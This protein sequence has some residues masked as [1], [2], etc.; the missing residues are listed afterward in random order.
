MKRVSESLRALSLLSVIVT[1]GLTL[2]CSSASPTGA[3]NNRPTDKLTIERI[4]ADPSLNGP[5]PRALKVAPDG[6]RVTYLKEKASDFQKLDL[7]GFDLKTRQNR[8]LVDSSELQKG[9]EQLSAEEKARRERMR[10]SSSGIVEYSWS[11]AGNALIFPL[12]GGLFYYPVGAEG[13]KVRRLTDGKHHETDAHLSSH[14]NFVSFLRD[15]DLYLLNTRSGREQRITHDGS[16]TVKNGIAEFVAQE[17]MGRFDGQWWSKDESRLAFTR[18]DE[19][20]VEVAKRYEI[21]G[22]GFEVFEQ[23]YPRTGTRNATVRLGVT[24]AASPGRIRWLDLG[25]NSDIYLARVDWLPDG[26]RLAVQVESRDQKRLELRFYDTETGKSQLILTETDPKWLD[27]TNDLHFLKY[28]S[29]FIW[30]AERDG[31]RHLALYDL[32]GKLLRQLTSGHWPVHEFQATDTEE[33]YAYFTAARETPLE[34][35]LYRVPLYAAQGAITRVT[36]TEGWHQISMPEGARIFVDTF[37]SPAQPEQVSVHSI[38][39]TRLSYI[40]ENRLDRDHPL[41]PYLSSFSRPEFGILKGAGGVDLYYELIKPTGYRPGHPYPVIVDVYGGPGSQKV[42]KSWDRRGRLWHQILADRG[43]VVFQ[44][45]NRGSAAR[46]HA[47]HTAIYHQLGQVEVEDQKAGVEFLVKSGIADPKRIGIFGW[48]Y[49][50][51]MALMTLLKEPTTFAAAVSVAP[52]TD[53]TLYDTHYTERFLGTPEENPEGYRLS[54]VLPYVSGLRGRLLMVHGMA[55]DNVLFTN[56][57]K[58]YK[59]LQ[60]GVLPFEMMAYPGSKHGI[61]GKLR[62]THLFKTVTDFFER[63]LVVPNP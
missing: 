20:G 18:T 23:R 11:D 9:E 4:F 2:G 6:S 50:G 21:G 60:D 14:G 39:G 7:W 22:D 15:A 58:I 48:S 52:V 54:G 38:D 29:A 47:F 5:S 3:A 55:D 19:S 25:P 24:A 1:L 32:H 45:D 53:W 63:S 12:A 8:M 57:T 62:Q 31:Y 43:F 46:G 44:L 37:S 13:A 33:K 17:E 30:G 49:G 41:A 51:Y 26:R 34:Q 61:N 59:A 27:L 28:S 40:E 36:E 10:I 56:S 16:K 42:R 35:H